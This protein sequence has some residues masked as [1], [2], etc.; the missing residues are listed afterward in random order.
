VTQPGSSLDIKSPKNLRSKK[1][2]IG[3]EL[4]ELELSKRVSIGSS[5]RNISSK[6]ELPAIDRLDW[7]NRPKNQTIKL[8]SNLPPDSQNI[9]LENT[10]NMDENYR[11]QP[12]LPGSEV[13]MFDNIDDSIGFT[14]YSTPTDWTNLPLS[15]R[16]RRLKRAQNPAARG[17]M[18]LSMPVPSISGNSQSE[19]S[20]FIAEL[21]VRRY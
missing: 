6:V 5:K 12:S 9:Q 19:E 13:T 2:I 18:S 8:H 21:Y 16:I 10:Y 17:L 11:F 7:T 14:S 20:I 1:L 3:K 15:N 4:L